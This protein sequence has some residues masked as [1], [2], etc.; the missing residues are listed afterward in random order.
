MIAD[1]HRA[2]QSSLSVPAVGLQGGT[3]A[4]LHMR[5]L[6]PPCNAAAAAPRKTE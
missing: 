6:S 5:N 4:W 1:A 2:E 3:G